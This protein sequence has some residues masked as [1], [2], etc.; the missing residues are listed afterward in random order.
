[1]QW[2]LNDLIVLRDAGVAI[3]RELFDSVLEY[4]N[5]NF[6]LAPCSTCNTPSLGQHASFCDRASILWDIEWYEILRQR[7]LEPV[8]GE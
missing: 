1:M 8:G 3:D 4:E 6:N 7:E 2:T 5:K